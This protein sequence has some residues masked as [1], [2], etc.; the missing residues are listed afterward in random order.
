LCDEEEADIQKAL[1]LVVVVVD[2][3][4]DIIA[5]VI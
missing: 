2:D 3:D 1:L 4:G 5:F